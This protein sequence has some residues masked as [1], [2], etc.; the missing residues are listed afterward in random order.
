GPQRTAQVRGFKAPATWPAQLTK[1]WQAPVG[2]G[3]ASP[4]VIGDSIYI[5]T[6]EAE[7]EVV[8]RLD[9]TTSKETWKD[10]YP[11]PYT[12]NPAARAHGKGPKSTPVYADGCLYTLGI[13][14]TLSCYDAKTG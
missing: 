13:S 3:Y 14:G 11:A 8:R 2:E 6:R 10:T 5:F 12:M 1:K 7:N 4:L 9:L